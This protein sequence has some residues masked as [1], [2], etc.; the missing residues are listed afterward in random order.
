MGQTASSS[1]WCGLLQ[2][3][4]GARALALLHL[5]LE[6]ALRLIKQPVVEHHQPPPVEHPRPAACG[7]PQ[8]PALASP[9]LVPHHA[10]SSP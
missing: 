6:K 8:Q 5:V 1:V 9:A 7:S 3:A 2:I 10:S 4:C